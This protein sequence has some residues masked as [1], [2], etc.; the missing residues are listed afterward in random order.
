LRKA[1]LEHNKQIEGGFIGSLLTGLAS[2]AL[3]SLASFIMD[4][5]SGKGL[6]LK[7]GDNIVKLQQSGNG[8]FL[9]PYSSTWQADNRPIRDAKA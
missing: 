3:P 9:K 5:I 7:R 2:A 8:L 6:Y 1:Q 4:K